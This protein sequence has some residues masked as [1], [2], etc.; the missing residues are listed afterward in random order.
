M[1]R[2]R[3]LIKEIQSALPEFVQACKAKDADF[4]LAWSE[5]TPVGIT[6]VIE[7]SWHAAIS[8]NTSAGLRSTFADQSGPVHC[9]SGPLDWQIC[10]IAFDAVQIDPALG[11]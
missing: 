7:R 6:H 2:E 10:W 1:E 9:P 4:T 5:F 3:K 11:A 8:L